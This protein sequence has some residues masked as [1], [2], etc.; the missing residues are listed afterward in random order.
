MLHGTSQ[1]RRL[2]LRWPR[3]RQPLNLRNPKSCA[4]RAIHARMRRHDEQSGK[5]LLFCRKISRGGVAVYP[6]NIAVD[7]RNRPSERFSKA[8]HNLGAVYRAE[9]A[10]CR[11][12]PLL[13][14]ALRSARIAG[15]P[16]GHLAAADSERAWPGLPGNGRLRSSRKNVAARHGDRPSSSGGANQP[17]EPMR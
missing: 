7:H 8:F 6:R 13:L 17:W 2:V 5:H 9:G 1:L 4:R 15:R 12:G 16:L 14:R 11:C 10:I 3:L